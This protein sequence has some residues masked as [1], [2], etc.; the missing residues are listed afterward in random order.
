MYKARQE[1]L[2]DLALI[3]TNCHAYN[4]AQG[5]NL[6]MEQD[7][8]MLH[9][10]GKARYI[11]PASPLYIPYIFPISPLYLPRLEARERL[12]VLLEDRPAF[13]VQHLGVL[14]HVQVATLVSV[15]G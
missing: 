9:E 14:L 12:V 2:D 8:R 3:V 5:R 11:S 4:T 6:H 15:R 10:K 1:V 7:A 13:L